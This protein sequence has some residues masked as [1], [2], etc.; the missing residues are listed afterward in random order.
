[1]STIEVGKI[2]T[3]KEEVTDSVKVFHQYYNASAK[4]IKYITFTYVPYNSVNDIVTC[5]ASGKSEVAG[6]LTGP[7]PPKHKSY[8]EWKS[9]WFNPTVRT[10]V[11]TSILVQFMDNTEEL[12]EGKDIVSMDDPNSVYYK[13]VEEEKRKEAERK[14][15]DEKLSGPVKKL[16]DDDITAETVSSVLSEFKD[17]EETIFEILIRVKGK[18]TNGYLIGDYIEKNYSSN[19]SLMNKAVSFWKESVSNQQT[20]YGLYAAQI[21]NCK[22]F[23]EKYAEKIRKYEPTYEMP[24]EQGGAISRLIG[25]ILGTIVY[26]IKKV[27]KK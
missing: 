3:T 17:D 6:K 11:I 9:M 5:T 1:M 23:P 19:K 10:A 26:M 21:K 13:A 4:E 24:E 20:L 8:V 18:V 2:L 27:S 16:S 7:I 25:T 14:A 12:I 22:G 15:K